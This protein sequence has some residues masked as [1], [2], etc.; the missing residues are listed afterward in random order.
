MA[1]GEKAQV[2]IA[3]A[4]RSA[5]RKLGEAFLGDDKVGF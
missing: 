2:K 3:H 4:A 1:C 5:E